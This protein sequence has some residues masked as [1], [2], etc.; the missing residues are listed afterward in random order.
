MTKEEVA[1][2][3]KKMEIKENSVIVVTSDDIDSSFLHEIQ[4]ALKDMQIS[5]KVPIIGLSNDSDIR[6]ESIDEAITYLTTLK[7]SLK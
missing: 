5:F 1:Y 2:A 3:I 6:I 4:R 7:E